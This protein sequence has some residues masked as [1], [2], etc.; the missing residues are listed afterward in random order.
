M[1]KDKYLSIETNQSVLL[2]N[3]SWIEAETILNKYEVVLISLGSRM[4]EHGPHLPLNND[5]IMAERLKD[6]VIEQIAVA[7]LPT[8]QYGFY[9]SFLE[10]PGSISINENAFKEFIMDICKSMHG[11]GK[12]KFY[13]LNTGISTLRPLQKAAE[14]LKEL[15]IVL[16]YLNLLEIESKLETNLLQQEGGTHADEGETSIM[17]YLQPDIVD[18]SKAVKDY[19][20]RSDR[21]GLTRDP[22]GSGLYSPTGVYGDSTLA[23]EE[24]GKIL[25]EAIIKEVVSSIKK[26]QES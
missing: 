11:Y 1:S 15:D 25:V 12:R 6:M 26:M 9:P 10:Y 20:A 21:K 17:L 18:M 16:N 24:K 8:L 3:L 4:K 23:S 5:Y 13:I 19:D 7:I 2:E 14:D 22:E